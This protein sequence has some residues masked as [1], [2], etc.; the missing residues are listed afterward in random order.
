MDFKDVQKS[1]CLYGQPRAM[2]TLSPPDTQGT[3]EEAALPRESPGYCPQI[4]KERK[5]GGLD[6]TPAWAFCH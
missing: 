3:A 5:E 4:L 6:L 1:K 2:W